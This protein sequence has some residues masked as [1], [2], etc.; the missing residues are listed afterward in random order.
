MFSS[1]INCPV[2]SKVVNKSLAAPIPPWETS[3]ET[4]VDAEEEEL[5][6]FL[7][8]DTPAHLFGICNPCSFLTTMLVVEP[9]L[10]E[11]VTEAGV[12]EK[13]DLANC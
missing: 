1:N 10:V 3:T 9:Q 8:L 11:S 4:F 5:I 6:M 13:E 7:L 2:A 12:Y